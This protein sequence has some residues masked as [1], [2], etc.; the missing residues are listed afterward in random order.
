MLAYKRL[1]AAL[2][3]EALSTDSDD[4]RQD[5]DAMFKPKT[6]LDEWEA[7][8]WCEGPCAPVRNLFKYLVDRLSEHVSS[9]GVIV[10]VSVLFIPWS[11]KL[12]LCMLSLMLAVLMPVL[13]AP[14]GLS[15][16][17]GF[18]PMPKKCNQP[19]IL[20]P[21][22]F[23]LLGCAAAAAMIPPCLMLPRLWSCLRSSDSESCLADAGVTSSNGEWTFTTVELFA[24]FACCL[25]G[26][27]LVVERMTHLM[28]HRAGV[29]ALLLE[30]EEA[31]V[32]NAKGTLDPWQ[33]SEDIPPSRQVSP[34]SEDKVPSK[35]SS[36][37]VR[38]SMPTPYSAGVPKMVDKHA[39]AAFTFVKT[40]YDNVRTSAGDRLNG[41]F[42]NRFLLVFQAATRQ[43]AEMWFNAPA[44][45]A[46]QKHVSLWIVFIAAVQALLPCFFRLLK[47][48]WRD[49]L[50]D[51]GFI[52]ALRLSYALLSFLLMLSMC[53]R[54]AEQK[55]RLHDLKLQCLLT[56][57]LSAF[58]NAS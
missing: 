17:C 54:V 45:R 22:A 23:C 35:A 57:F 44:F 13:L 16:A 9:S 18:Y 49:P 1:L 3:D 21:L 2:P 32:V 5:G 46:G 31:E 33:L 37:S 25:L 7:A 56:L 47:S 55:S 42:E 6:N 20:A 24:P 34:E 39:S 38:R 26:A 29:V 51:S 43:E 14:T 36:R 50:A 10:N 28:V 53:H 15:L 8:V 41:G 40:L 58:P 52:L 30:F 4:D 48:G 11:L 19:R 27:V 12:K